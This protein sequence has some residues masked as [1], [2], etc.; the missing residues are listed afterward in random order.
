M[1][2]DSLPLARSQI[3]PYPIHIMSDAIAKRNETIAEAGCIAVGAA[4][5]A[6]VYFAHDVRLKYFILGSGSWGFG[7]MLKMLLHALVMKRLPR[8]TLATQKSALLN[9]LISGITELGL[10][11]V[12]FIFLRDLT[13][14]QL[15]AF[16][17]GIGAIE[18]W[19]VATT[20]N[21][22][23]GTVLEEGAN[24]LEATIAQLPSGQRFFWERISGIIERIA[25]LMTHIGSRGLVYVTCRTLNPLPALLAL[26]AF[27]LLDGVLGFRTL[28]YK[29]PGQIRRLTE[30]FIWFTV[31][32]AAL[33]VLFAIYWSRIN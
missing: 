10:A 8:E 14:W 17:T 4:A 3:I 18:A 2:R 13:L 27:I 9:G 26:G 7:V 16:G 33:L 30:F 20:P 22:L 31:I 12:F 23:K 32:A 19:V 5:V 29:G 11:V 21:L 15:I 24:A 25:A 28:M 6:Y 1:Y